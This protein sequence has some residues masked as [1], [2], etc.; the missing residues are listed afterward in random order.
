M[1]EVEAEAEADVTIYL[2]D[3]QFGA[4]RQ[5]EIIGLL[6]KGVFKITKLA[7]VPQGVR[8]FNSRFVDEVKNAGT[9]KAF[10]KSRLVV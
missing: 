6:E 7:D 10:E 3:D 2:Q 8:L 4:S 1:T 9:T 5:K